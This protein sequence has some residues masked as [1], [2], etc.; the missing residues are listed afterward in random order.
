VTTTVAD[1]NSDAEGSREDSSDHGAC[2][3][4]CPGE[5]K[6]NG[7]FTPLIVTEVPARTVGSGVPGAGTVVDERFVPK[8]D[9]IDP[10][11]I[12]WA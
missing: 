3:L 7:A 12:G 10:G 9:T 8:I 11:E 4:I 6:N 1:L 2:R 5:T